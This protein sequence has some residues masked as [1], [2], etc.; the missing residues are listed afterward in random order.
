MAGGIVAAGNSF[1]LPNFVGE[2]FA[3]SREDT[4]FLS[5]IGG[6][7]GGEET[8]STLFQWT[9]YD[10][11]DP[12][13][14]R[15]AV[16]GANAP[17]PEAR[18]RGNVTNVV[19][20]HHEAVEI[21]YTKQAA[22]GEFA[23]TGSAKANSVGLAGGN[24]VQNELD[25][26]V[27]QSLKQVA[28]D[29][30]ASFITGEFANPSSNT[31]RATRGLLEAISTNVIA[32]GGADLSATGQELLL[33]LMQEIWDN[34]GIREG[35]TRTLLTNS[36]QKR[37]I[38]KYFKSQDYEVVPASRN[39]G[40][41]N[42]TTVETDFGTLNIMLEP[43]MPQDEIAVVSLGECAPVFLQIPG[44]GFLFVEDL[45]KVGSADRKQIYGEVG[46]K[47]G[48]ESHH[49]KLTGLDTGAS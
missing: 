40:G 23:S 6:L 32:T 12:E 37:R 44:K 20:I 41:V 13:D 8:M 2:L 33:D 45:A 4:P 17:T 16:E 22:V 35:E 42:V 43:A 26:Q 10:L 7:T 38:T 24:A 28:R 25:W 14:D 46:L 1:N 49:G 18:V 19:E 47:Y 34:G 29:I 5:A 15:Q 39:I 21:S 3:I 27:A 9:T 30:N 48:L 11:R 36:T 31:A